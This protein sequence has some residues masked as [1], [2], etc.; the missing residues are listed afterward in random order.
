MTVNELITELEGYQRMGM[1]QEDVYLYVGGR[2]A[3]IDR[4]EPGDGLE[5]VFLLD[6]ETL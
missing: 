4:T 6:K 1:G 2:G 3:R 5:D